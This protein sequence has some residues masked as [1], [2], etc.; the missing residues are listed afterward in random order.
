MIQ[1]SFQFRDLLPSDFFY[2]D[3]I[4]YY[5]KIKYPNPSARH[6][7]SYGLRKSRSQAKWK[8]LSSLLGLGSEIIPEK[9][10]LSMMKSGSMCAPVMT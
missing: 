6:S 9:F 1:A 4:A 8:E 2:H 7:G 5:S 3:I 10:H